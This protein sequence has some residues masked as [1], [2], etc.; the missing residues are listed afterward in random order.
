M[1]VWPLR[2]DPLSLS[3]YGK[4]GS[5]IGSPVRTNGKTTVPKCLVWGGKLPGGLIWKMAR[6]LGGLTVGVW[7]D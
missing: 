3:L 2:G 4:G 1:A 7:C 6:V 5:V